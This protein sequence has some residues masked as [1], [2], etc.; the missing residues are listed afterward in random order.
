MTISLSNRLLLAGLSAV[1][2]STICGVAQANPISLYLGGSYTHINSVFDNNTENLGGGSVDTSSINGTTLPFVYCVDILHNVGV[3]NT[4]DN[5]TYTLD[6][7]VNG[8][9]VHNADKVAVLL[10]KYAA[11][12]GSNLDLQGG[13]QAAIWHEIYDG[14]NGHTYD[15]ASSGN[16]ADL[17]TAY[18]ADLQFLTDHPL[19][20]TDLANYL[21]LTPAGTNTY[22]GLVTSNSVPGI[23][24]PAFYQM[25]VFL[26]GGG[27]MAL[28]LRRKNKK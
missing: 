5:T 4:Y 1:A 14:T 27:L 6:G 17:V 16:S 3:P 24:E 2:M 26:A 19:A 25:G 22:Q 15:L 12:A 10:A 20:H 7:T 13:L 18:N 28:R 11:D 23:P 8:A 9:A 21:W